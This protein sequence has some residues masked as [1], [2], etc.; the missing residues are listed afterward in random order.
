MSL[1]AVFDQEAECFAATLA[2]GAPSTGVAVHNQL[3]GRSDSDA[4]P[5]AAISGLE[6]KLTAIEEKVDYSLP[7]ATS[8]A[9]GGIKVGENLAITADG[10]LSVLTTNEAEQDNTKPMTSAGVHTQLGNIEI[11]LA[12]L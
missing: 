11:L 6:S 10:V 5:I 1:K 4:H 2:G 12:A 3:S 8:E 9:L 7:A